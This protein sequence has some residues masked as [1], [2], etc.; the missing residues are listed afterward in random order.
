VPVPSL[1]SVFQA[2][3]CQDAWLSGE[4]VLY[5]VIAN[6]RKAVPQWTRERIIYIFAYMYGT[7]E[8]CTKYCRPFDKSKVSHRTQHGDCPSFEPVCKILYLVYIL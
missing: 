8:A 4:E 5:T 6:G 7:Y 2:A 3:S 1:P